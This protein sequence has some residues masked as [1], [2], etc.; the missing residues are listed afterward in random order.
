MSSAS[1]TGQAIPLWRRLLLIGQSNRRVNTHTGGYFT[2]GVALAIVMCIAVYLVQLGTYNGD[3]GSG[4]ITGEKL[5][6]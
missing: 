1:E 2:G 6:R 3:F 5:R 4:I